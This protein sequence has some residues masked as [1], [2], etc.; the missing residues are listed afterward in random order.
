MSW[1]T[2]L[3]KIPLVFVSTSIVPVLS[4]LKIEQILDDRFK[5]SVN[6]LC[7]AMINVIPFN[8]DFDR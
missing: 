1:N 3:I 2:R 8:L 4:R 6:H 5:F 7:S